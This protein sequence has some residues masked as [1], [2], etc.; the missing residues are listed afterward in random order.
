M[1]PKI[2]VLCARSWVIS[3]FL[4]L[5]VWPM[6]SPPWAL[7]GLGRL[8]RLSADL[9]YLRLHGLPDQP[10]LYGDPGWPTAISFDE[11]RKAPKKLFRDSVIFLEGCFGGRISSAFLDAGARCVVG[12]RLVTWGRRYRLGPSSIVGR[13]FVKK[14]REGAPPEI[15]LHEALGTVPAQFRAGWQVYNKENLK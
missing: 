5:G 1:R 13:G 7:G 3:S 8:D 12:S 2:K 9:V 4:T 11:I 14:T 6:T 10:Y 15:A